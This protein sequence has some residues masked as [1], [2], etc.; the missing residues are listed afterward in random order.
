MQ[1]EKSNLIYMVVMSQVIPSW[2]VASDPRKFFP[3][4]LYW[5]SL[6]MAWAP[7]RA[8]SGTWVVSSKSERFVHLPTNTS[9]FGWGWWTAA[10]WLEFQGKSPGSGSP[11]RL[12]LVKHPVYQLKRQIMMRRERWSNTWTYWKEE[13]QKWPNYS[14]FLFRVLT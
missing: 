13:H 7:Y 3:L 10:L 5:P 4:C 11:S 1:W 9:F 12:L 2:S 14:K 6:G 8:T